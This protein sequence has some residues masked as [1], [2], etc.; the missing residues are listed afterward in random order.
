MAWIHHPL[1][2]D[3]VYGRTSDQK[4]HLMGQVLHA[5]VLGFIHPSTGKYMEFR[6]QLPEYFQELLDKFRL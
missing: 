4:Y 6:A 1:L 3:D 2:G 5:G